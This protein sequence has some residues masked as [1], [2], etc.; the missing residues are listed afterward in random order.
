MSF[1]WV[2]PC[3]YGPCPYDVSYN[4]DCEYYCGADEPPD[5]PEIEEEEEEEED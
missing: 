2:T 1:K 3:D 5:F 4:C